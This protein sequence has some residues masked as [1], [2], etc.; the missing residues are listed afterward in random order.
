MHVIRIFRPSCPGAAAVTL[1]LLFTL[2][3][4]ASARGQTEIQDDCDIVESTIRV[5]DDDPNEDELARITHDDARA[6][7]LAALPGATIEDSDLEEED[8]YLVYEVELA[9]NDEEFEAYVDAGNQAVLC[10]ERDD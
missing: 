4:V 9:L 6:A 1:A 7:A 2:G 8:G 3:T 10:I 5:T